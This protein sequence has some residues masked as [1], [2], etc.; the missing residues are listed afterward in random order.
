MKLII[1]GDSI[2]KGTYTDAKKGQTSPGSIASPNFAE[3]LKEMLHATE[4]IN[5]GT[6]GI[7]Y[8]SCS[9]VNPDYAL[10]KTC[11]KATDGDVVILAAGTNDYSTNV[12]LGNNE[13]CEDIS[14]YGAVEI[15]FST[16]RRNNPKAKVYVVLPIPRQNEEKNIKGYVLDDYRM[17]LEYKAGIHGFKVIDGRKMSIDPKKEEDRSVYMEDGLH[18]NTQGH[19]KY[20]DMLYGEMIGDFAAK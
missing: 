17:A 6:N 2:A 4:M 7:S 19:R 16:I 1:L 11:M 8:S 10:S 5:L 13:D 15:V 12:K 14:F 3:C 9:S 18:P 20:A